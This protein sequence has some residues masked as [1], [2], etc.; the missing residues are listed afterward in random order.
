MLPLAQ[1]PRKED[2]SFDD[3]MY[4]IWKRVLLGVDLTSD[5]TI[6]GNKTFTVGMIVPS[7]TTT[8]KNA[9]TPIAGMVI[10]DT[11]LAKVCIYTGAAWQTVISA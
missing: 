8:Q 1:P 2:R 7:Y 9:L 6:E 4:R 3:W 11:T 5:Q 10:L